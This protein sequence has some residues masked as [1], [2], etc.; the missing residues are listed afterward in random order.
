MCL[1][2][3]SAE[4]LGWALVFEDI[5]LFFGRVPEPSIVDGGNIEVLG[6]SFDPSW[7]PFLTSVIVGDD[8]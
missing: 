2:D 3:P 8:Q 7:N 1:I 4:R 6:D 5:F